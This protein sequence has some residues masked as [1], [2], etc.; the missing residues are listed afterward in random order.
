MCVCVCLCV[1]NFSGK[2][3]TFQTGT[4]R[5]QIIQEKKNIGIVLK[6][7]GSKVMII[8]ITHSYVSRL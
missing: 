3:L 5:L 1:S 4:G 7:F 2:A 8:F 6:P